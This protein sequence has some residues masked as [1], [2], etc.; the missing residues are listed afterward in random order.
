M[1]TKSRVYI[2]VEFTGQSITRIVEYMHPYKLNH[3]YTY[4]FGWLW[5]DIIPLSLGNITNPPTCLRF[6][7]TQMYKYI[8]I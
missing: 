8:E 1:P 4:E 7:N 3:D 2:Y 5:N 6:D